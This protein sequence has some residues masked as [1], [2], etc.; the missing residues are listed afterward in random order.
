MIVVV[1]G[2]H[3][4]GT[5]AMSGLLHKNGIVMG[6]EEKKEFYPPP[7]KENPKGFWENVRFRRINDRILKMHGYRVKSFS[8]AIPMIYP[9]NGSE[10][11][12]KVLEIMRGLIIEYNSEFKNWGWKDPRTS[13]TLYPW[14]EVIKELNLLNDLRIIWMRRNADDIAHSMRKRGNQEKYKDHFVELSMKYYGKS[15]YYLYYVGYYNRL[16]ILQVDFRDDLLGRTG[17]TCKRLSEFL[18]YPIKDSSHIERR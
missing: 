15:H 1:L 14:M 5:S 7:I 10:A 12:N 13:L 3:R 18:N 8:P 17:R 16:K 9:L 6:R 11:D 4:S 2:M